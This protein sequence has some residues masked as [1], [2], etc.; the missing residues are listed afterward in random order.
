MFF[1]IVSNL[2]AQDKLL[3]FYVK[4]LHGDESISQDE[5]SVFV[6]E[7]NYYAKKI[8][9]KY[10]CGIEYDSIWAVKLN[11][12][13]IRA[14]KN[15]IETAE[16]ITSECPNL[17]SSISNY[18][19]KIDNHTLTV[20]GECD[21]KGIDY[22]ALENMLFKENF[23]QL[24]RCRR[25]LISELNKKLIGKWYYST[26][27]SE[28]KSGEKIMLTK[29]KTSDEC[30]WNIDKDLYFEDS[31]NSIFDMKKSHEFEWDID[32]G[33]IFLDILGGFNTDEK[34][35]IT[36]AN[37]GATFVLVEIDENNIILEFK[38]Q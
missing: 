22:E 27:K 23:K 4:Y 25:N 9:P 28:L 16:K 13:Q 12:K 20:K 26:P 8:S 10:Y 21:W 18:V 29:S 33:S 36:V 35:I 32:E 34:G 37:Y 31:C 24:E 14:C 1:G 11:K 15:F 3:P 6:V 2:F 38:W 30:F 7:N 5:L 17:S 19:I